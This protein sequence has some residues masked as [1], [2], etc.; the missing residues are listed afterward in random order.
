MPPSLGHN[1]T[2]LMNKCT[3]M[4]MSVGPDADGASMLPPATKANK[5]GQTAA[6]LQPYGRCLAPR[7]ID[8]AGHD[9]TGSHGRMHRIAN[10]TR[11]S[12]LDIESL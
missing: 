9:A 4:P 10:A 6:M 3:V 8:A 1:A 11:L 7:A 2:S 12:A 5:V